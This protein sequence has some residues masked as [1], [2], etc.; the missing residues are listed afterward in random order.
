MSVKR[1]VRR[2]TTATLVAA[3]VA[4]VAM[5]PGT[6]GAESR[7]ADC[8]NRLRLVR[9]AVAAYERD[10]SLLPGAAPAADLGGPEEGSR[11]GAL[12]HRQL[13][14]PR[15]RT[16]R[17]WVRGA[18]PPLLPELP[19]NPLTSSRELVILPAGADALAFAADCT[20]GWVYLARDGV[21]A[22]GFLPAGVVLPCGGRVAGRANEEERELALR[23]A[24]EVEDFRRWR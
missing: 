23:V 20:A 15:D 14:E 17:P 7:R 24:L 12:V 18:L 1:A 6:P 10:H 5:L 4:A 22:E 21:D 19:A 13:C 8:F 2:L 11:V 3:G 9:H 16:G